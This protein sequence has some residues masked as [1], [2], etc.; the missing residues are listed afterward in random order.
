MANKAILTGKYL[1]FPGYKHVSG[2]WK[3]RMSTLG[4]IPKRQ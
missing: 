3:N 4:F 1:G 2:A